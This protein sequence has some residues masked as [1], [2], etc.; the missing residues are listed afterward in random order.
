M[1]WIV[2]LLI[3]SIALAFQGWRMLRGRANAHVEATAA[4][5][6][7]GDPAAAPAQPSM[8]IFAG[9][10][11]QT[12]AVADKDPE[13]WTSGA[14]FLGATTLMQFLPDRRFELSH[15]AFDKIAADVVP[16]ARGLVELWCTF[17]LAWLTT[18]AARQVY[19]AEFRQD[20][21]TALYAWITINDDLIADAQMISDAIEFWFK[22]M[23]AA[24]VDAAAAETKGPVRPLV[25][26]I[27][28][29]FLSFDASSPYFGRAVEITDDVELTIAVVLE[30]AYT[31]ARP[32]I[33]ATVRKAGSLGVPPTPGAAQPAADE[34]SPAEPDGWDRLAVSRK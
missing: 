4:G 7:M 31:S 33:E 34:I 20:T 3:C 2:F 25:R 12:P 17:Y 9:L 10:F 23:D 16:E 28:R 13:T 26:F 18:Y 1:S 19:G 24:A 14:D 32:F 22:H 11:Q 29:R 6:R 21:M 30:V 15:E 8:G 5:A 27:A